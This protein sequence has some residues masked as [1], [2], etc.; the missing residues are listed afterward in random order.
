VRVVKWL[1]TVLG[2]GIL[3][4]G[5][6]VPGLASVLVYLLGFVVMAVGWNIP[7][8]RKY[9]TR[10]FR[11]W[12]SVARAGRD[13]VDPTVDAL[14]SYVRVDPRP[15]SGVCE[16][17]RVVFSSTTHERREESLGT[18]SLDAA[19]TEPPGGGSAL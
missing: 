15:R 13:P 19:C 16:V 18:A 4:S 17:T 14:D 12:D 1:V 11:S 8:R 7:V 3:F 5:I 2:V 10:Y 6:A 9:V